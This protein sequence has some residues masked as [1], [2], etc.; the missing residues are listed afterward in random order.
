MKDS[1]KTLR[2]SIINERGEVLFDNRTDSSALENH[3]ERPEVIKAL[4]NGVG[5]SERVSDTLGEITYYYAM[6]LGNE[7]I[8]RLALTSHNVT[9]ILYTFVPIAILCLALSAGIAFVVARRLTQRIIAPINNINLDAPELNEYE[10][11]VPLLKKIETQ[12]QEISMQLAETRQR[13]ET[14]L[15]IT[16]SMQEGLLLLNEK[17]NVLLANE[18]AL[19]ILDIDD[20]VGKNVIVLCRDLPF[21]EHAKACLNGQKSEGILQRNECIYQVLFNPVL[22]EESVGGAVVLLIDVTDKYAAETQR[23]AFSANVS[24]ELKTPLTTIAALSEMISDGTAKDMDVRP[25]AQ[26]IL[27][28]SRRLIYI[29]DDIIKLSAFDE[30]AFQKEFTPFNLYGLANTV[31][32]SLQENA[33]EK[34]VAITLKGDEELTLT[35]NMRMIDELLYNL[36]DNA[37]KYNREGGHITVSLTDMEGS[38][39][40]SVT[41]TGIGI[42]KA[43][44]DR[45]FERFYRVDKSRS[46]KTGGTGLGLSIVKHVAEFHG[47]SV[48]LE[49]EVNVG[50]TVVVDIQH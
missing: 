3:L 15:T 6:R 39:R 26:K 11:L 8:L 5:E 35:A 37:I 43:A 4:Q 45:V 31:I 1:L 38:V 23:K 49:S 34:N 22:E 12:K 24:H 27:L 30:A 25:F 46:K 28:Q 19:H 21:F 44:L 13:S 42:P 29:I 50:T 16:G 40:I 7:N 9:A 17:G 10:E 20:A 18:S 14:I 33:E 36:L 2:V 47:G 32:S 48:R 41:D